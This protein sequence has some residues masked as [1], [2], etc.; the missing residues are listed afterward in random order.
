MQHLTSV[1][2]DPFAGI[3]M[4]DPPPPD[5]NDDPNANDDPNDGEDD[6]DPDP[7]DQGD[8]KDDKDEKLGEAGVKA[9]QRE[10]QARKDAEKELKRIQRENEDASAKALREATEQVEQR[11]H[12]I[13]AKSAFKVALAEAGLRKGQDKMLRLLELEDVEVDDDG[14]VT[15][16]EEQV[17]NLKREFPELFARGS[18]S[19]G[20]GD[21]GSKGTPPNKPKSSAERL[22]ASVLGR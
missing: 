4:E 20:K 2:V 9:L 14:D 21:G 11:Y 22:A 13:I 15:G 18:E 7:N 6:G 3:R 10:R 8:P 16:V 17:R 1:T 12:G 19:R 5:P